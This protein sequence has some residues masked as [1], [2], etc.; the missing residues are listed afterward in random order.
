MAGEVI[1]VDQL[2]QLLGV[3][4]ELRQQAEGRWQAAQRELVALLEAYAPEEVDRRL[5]AGQPLDSLGVEDLGVLLRQQ[6]NA[7]P[8]PT[9]IHPDGSGLIVTDLKAQLQTSQSELA[10]LRAEHQRLAEQTQALNAERDGL[11]AQLSALQ[12][13]TAVRSITIPL[14]NG[15]PPSESAPQPD[16][17]TAWRAAKTFKRD[18]IV[19]RLLGETGLARRPEVRQQAAERLG[20]RK[21][22]GS[23][24]SLFKRLERLGLIEIFYPWHSSGSKTW[25]SSGS[26]TGGSLPGL[27]RL[28]E[29]GSLAY[30]LLC[31]SDPAQNEYDALLSRHVSPEHT[32]LNIQAADFLSS[33]NFTVD[34]F[35]PEIHLPDGGLFRPDLLARDQAGDTLY[36]EVEADANKNS[37]QRHA[38]WRNALQAGGGRLHIFCDNPSCM[39]FVR[40]EIN[41]TLGS[42]VKQCFLTN[43]VDLEAKKRGADGGIWLEMRP[44]P[45][46]KG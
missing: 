8:K 39:D 10:A 9:P 35:P 12:Q 25:H 15:N 40:N 5:K 41:R 20:I 30:W 13:A 16:W 4:A 46:A 7:R 28:T 36:L 2:R 11:H 21:P 42:Q 31:G 45:E 34:L 3:Q 1:T 24:Q 17:M 27:L 22:G 43:L 6:L 37:E 29:R 18:A 19:L 14:P 44:K 38:K 32:L 26:K 23:I 33:A